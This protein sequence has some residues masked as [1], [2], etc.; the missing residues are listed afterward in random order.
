MATTIRFDIDKAMADATY[1]NNFA[2]T[3]AKMPKH[4]KYTLICDEGS[5]G[6]KETFKNGTH[7]QLMIVVNEVVEHMNKKGDDE[8][9]SI[10][11]QKE[12]FLYFKET[13]AA[14]MDKFHSPPCLET[15]ME[16]KIFTLSTTLPILDWM[17]TEYGGLESAHRRLGEIFAAKFI[18]AF[19]DK[20]CPISHMC[21]CNTILADCLAHKFNR[22][23]DGIRNIFRTTLNRADNTIE[24][25]AG[26]AGAK[27]TEEL[28]QN[29]GK[30]D[31]LD[32][33]L[34]KPRKKCCYCE[35]PKARNKCAKCEKARYCD[36]TC[37]AADWKEHRKC[38]VKKVIENVD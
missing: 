14:L 8:W 6:V 34:E 38:C 10:K 21:K 18:K 29:E 24:F 22:E 19:V 27:Y 23:Q 26:L 11:T 2:A 1:R 30:P 28:R 5:D 9:R 20:G 33:E 13:A 25:T 15:L 7:A 31:Q 36:A 37:Q 3:V 32:T 12:L 35:A 16:K 4:K 17:L